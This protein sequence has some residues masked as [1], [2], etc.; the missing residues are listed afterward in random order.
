MEFEGLKSTNPDN[1]N[2]TVINF[3][4]WYFRTYENLFHVFSRNQSLTGK[5]VANK[6]ATNGDAGGD[7]FIRNG[8]LPAIVLSGNSNV[9]NSLG[10][11]ESYQIE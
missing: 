6:V 5:F 4:D 1:K 11:M 7:K 8:L 10:R 9:L 3:I 2:Y